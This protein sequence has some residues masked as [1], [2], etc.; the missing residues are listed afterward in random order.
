MKQFCIAILAVCLAA[1]LFAASLDAPGSAPM[2]SNISVTWDAPGEQY[3][4]VYV[5]EA[6][7]ADDASGI[8]S[9]SITSGK[10]PLIL[11]LPEK[12]GDYELRYWSIQQKQVLVR[13]PL[14]IE[15]VPTSLRAAA[16]V[17]QGADLEV[18][19]EGPGNAYDGIALF[20]AG[21]AEGSKS[22]TRKAILSR[23][24]P[25]VLRMP[26]QPGDYELRYITRREKIVKATLPVTVTGVE[27]SLQAADTA[28]IG[29]N[30][31]VTWEGPGTNYDLIGLFPVGATATAR[32]VSSQG[33]LNKKNPI[34]LK[35]PE[36]SGAYELRYVTTGS[37]AVLATRPLTITDTSATI[38]APERAVAAWPLNVGWTGPGNDYDSIALYPANAAADVKAVTT[39][40][41]LGGKNP[42]VINLPDAE[43]DYEL[44]YIT[45][46]EHKVLAVQPLLIKPAGRLA[47]SFTGQR[48][49]SGAGG[50][51]A[52]ELVLDASGSMLQRVGSGE[53]RISIAKAVLTDLV[54]NYLGENTGFALRVFG[55]KE[56]DSCRT[57]L[58]IPFS[59]LNREQA[60]ARID[61]VNAM[62]LART[63][64]ADS[65]AKVPQDLA[66]ATG[67]KTIIL[68]TDG[69][70]TCDGDPEAVIT[71]LRNRGLDL[72]LS[73]VGFG[74]DDAELKK[75]FS[76]W[77]E[78]GGGSYFDTTSA[79]ELSR[80]LRYVISGPFRVVNA[81]GETVGEG[82]IG[83]AE[84]VLPAG[85][86]RVETIGASP[87]S[88]ENVVIRPREL[89]E[90]SF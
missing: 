84:I 9:A 15:D 86:Y 88:I 3:D 89:T 41:I 20:P 42:V 68:I 29:S 49:I 76:H 85:T 63:P 51:G 31:E 7:A 61:S 73:I 66:G 59:A 46:R 14:K 24:N 25:Q 13:Q 74:I 67:P 38:V 32:A 53:R 36:T 55:H 37:K 64:I 23:R 27:A 56:A 90:A 6:G 47:V 34:V 40:S 26:D 87:R 2:G 80:S 77:A 35:L 58:E 21:A 33:I 45:A 69:E 50:T 57:D 11:A 18:H 1:P 12:P 79:E 39:G 28:G 60:A 43:G 16:S 65:L 52:V 83:G 71:D 44:R 78:L 81:A 82:V 19:W 70:E 30:L 62:N 10:N 8:T 4:S 72:R 5:V 17:P 54:T 75:T 48:D 22:I